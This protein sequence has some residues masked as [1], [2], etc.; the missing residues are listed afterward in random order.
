MGEACIALSSATA[1][2]KRKRSEIKSSTGCSAAMSNDDYD[3]D[4][5]ETT[6]HRI[7]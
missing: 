4:I 5:I 2:P 3:R 1:V 7:A 6:R